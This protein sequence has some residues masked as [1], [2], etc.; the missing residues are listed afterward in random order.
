MAIT[1]LVLIP[2]GYAAYFPPTNSII[3]LEL[4]TL[5]RASRYPTLASSSL[6]SVAISPIGFRSIVLFKALAVFSPW[7]ASSLVTSLA[8]EHISRLPTKCDHYSMLDSFALFCFFWHPTNP[9]SFSLKHNLP[10]DNWRCHRHHRLHPDLFGVADSSPLQSKP[11]T[12][13]CTQFRAYFP[14]LRPLHRGHCADLPWL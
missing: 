10:T 14:W 2:S 13:P 7:L 6:V 11:V 5:T 9:E 1:W 12:P 8:R 3:C 4:S